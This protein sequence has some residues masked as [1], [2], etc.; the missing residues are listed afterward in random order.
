MK[1]DAAAPKGGAGKGDNS[2]RPPAR[3]ERFS[4]PRQA[5][6]AAPA[7][8]MAAAFAKLQTKR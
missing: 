5:Q 8:A 2:Y 7:S 3:G 6:G 1:L 4:N